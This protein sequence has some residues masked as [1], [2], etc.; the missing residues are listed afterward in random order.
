MNLT[1][2]TLLA[3]SGGL[4]AAATL[5]ACGS[6]TG[7]S[8]PSASPGTT[9]SAA[10]PALAQW[11]HQYGEDGVEA[12]VKKWAADYPDA[13]VS[14]NWYVGDYNKALSA[15]LLTPKGPDV[16]EAENGASIDMIKGGQVAD[17]TDLVGSAKADFMAPVINRMTYQ[18][19][20]W[21]IPQTVDMQLLYYRPSLL[22][23][24]GLQPPKTFDEF[25]AAA[26]AMKTN[27]M[28][29]FFAGND[30]GVSVL[31]NMLI[32]SAG[33]EQLNADRTAPAFNTPDLYAAATAYRTLFASGALLKSASTDWYDATP[34]YSGE[35]AMQ[36]GGLW[37]L[38]KATEALG[39]DVGV[40]PFP[41]IGSNGRQ[42]VVF[43]AF[44]ACVNA[45]SA[46]VDAGKEFIKWLWVDQDDKQV[47][48][49]NAFGTHIPAKPKLF[50][51]ASKVQSGPGA[52]AARFVNEMGHATD[53][54]WT[55]VTSQAFQ[56]ALEN[57]VKKNADPKTEFT[58]AAT[59][60]TA[61]LKRING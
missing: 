3:A 20:L 14:V 37:D 15:A 16:F 49:S 59:A 36:W 17:L 6:N 40:L 24:A 23:K 21:A 30:G 45:K 33:L 2:R 11:Y 7:R 51:Q 46:N 35:A 54:L 57:V 18:D 9:G 61:E 12:A 42:A 55:S 39:D 10:K 19:K 38:P 47:E 53:L 25:V 41:A 27:D 4:A 50:A 13:A 8:T 28:G 48:F 31:G 29:G 5:A 58:K 56:A 26:K 1:R 22:R 44:G 34:F 43:G 32:W 52:D 60:A